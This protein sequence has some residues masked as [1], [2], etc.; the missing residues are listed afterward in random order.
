M[1]TKSTNLPEL[2]G[3][4]VNTTFA[5][6]WMASGRYESTGRHPFG[7]R[8]RDREYVI[9]EGLNGEWTNGV[10]EAERVFHDRVHLIVGVDEKERMRATAAYF[11]L[12]RGAALRME[13]LDLLSFEDLLGACA[14]ALVDLDPDC[15]PEY[16]ILDVVANAEA[17]AEASA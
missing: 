10:S 12:N 11:V 1:S 17:S 15:I 2:T 13:E 9:A 7:T 6:W 8:L 14:L 5:W 16:D 3:I 4:R